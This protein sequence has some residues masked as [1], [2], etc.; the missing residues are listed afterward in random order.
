MKTKLLLSILIFVSSISVYSQALRQTVQNGDWNTNSTWLNGQK[1]QNGD[2]VIIRHNVTNFNGYNIGQ[3]SDA[4][5]TVLPGCSLTGSGTMGIMGNTSSFRNEGYV[6]ISRV[7]P[8]NGAP[9]FI[10]MGICSLSSN[11]TW[12]G[13]TS[14]IYNFGTLHIDGN[15]N[16]QGPSY[17]YNYGTTT[18]TGRQQLL[19][20]SQ[21]H[22]YGTFNVESSL[23]NAEN[24]QQ[25]QIY[26][27]S[28]ANYNVTGGIYLGG[29]S[30]NRIF[31]Y[32]Q[33][34]A[35]YIESHDNSVYENMGTTIVY[36]D[37]NNQGTLNN[38]ESGYIR[39]DR[40]FFNITKGTA[41]VDNEGYI[42]IKEDFTNDR[43]ITGDGNIKYNQNGSNTG[44]ITGT[45][46][47]CDSTPTLNNTV[48][49]NSGSISGSTGNCTSFNPPNPTLVNLSEMSGPINVCTNATGIVFS[50]NNIT[51]P[52]TSYVW[53]V[54][55]GWN[56]VSGQ[57]TNSITVNA[58]NQP[59]A[60]QVIATNTN[61]YAAQSKFVSISGSAPSQPNNINVA[62]T[63]AC[64]G[65]PGLAYSIQPVA[66]ATS[67]TWSVPSGWA[68]VNGQGTTS[69][70]VVPGTTSGTMS[71]TANNG[72]GSSTARTA[73]VSAVGGADAGTDQVVCGTSTNLAANS[74]SGTRF[75]TKISGPASITSS[76]SATTSVTNLGSGLNIFTW[77]VTVSGCTDVDTVIIA[78]N[79][80]A[81]Y[82]RPNVLFDLDS[83]YNIIKNNNHNAN[84]N[85]VLQG[86]VLTTPSDPDGT[87]IS[88]AITN[89]NIPEGVLFNS[90]SGVFSIDDAFSIIPGTYNLTVTT[91]DIFN[92]Q[93]ILSVSLQ[94]TNGQSVNPLPVEFISVEAQVLNNLVNISWSTAWEINNDYFTILKSTDGI[95]FSS[96]GVV[97]GNGTTN[98]I[99]NYN[100]IDYDIQND[101]TFYKIQQTDFDGT[102]DFSP[103]VII[104]N[105][106]QSVSKTNEPKIYPNPV[107]N[108]IVN[109]S[110]E[111]LNVRK[112]YLINSLG[113]S[114]FVSDINSESKIEINT[115]E[116]KSGL[117]YIKLEGDQ[118]TIN[119]LIIIN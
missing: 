101:N 55:S 93:S 85:Q 44:T 108:G 113:Q 102:I 73:T 89:G 35:N 80:S 65:T 6:A 116:Y 77:T 21:V 11:Q 47:I 99:S 24:I 42:D 64:A 78:R 107:N 30:S 62:P 25:G 56:I 53:Q 29:N 90:T 46:A 69:I 26:N 111:N 4:F 82:N 97:L 12:T 13:N 63:S 33:L 48:D 96:I 32:G 76:S 8:V 27:Y 104:R 15:V 1:P 22:N 70:Q 81:S 36:T 106:N 94:F 100:F 20:G 61:G 41:N 50:V 66:N 52:P 9:T 105:N 83:A 5:L 112:I 14:Y 103:V 16:L 72:C 68:I 67:Y 28:G 51:L 74:G 10:N 39:V 118:V 115:K 23:N 43:L 79:C 40:D 91:T 34:T 98:E 71:V 57:G 17:F 37:Y 92:Y 59:G 87:I 18:Q 84:V 75:W 119:P 117:Y 114:I 2:D 31:N 109:I 95:N 86:T 3:N 110:I 54:P 58:N 88:A 38:Y 19:T 7:N 45:N 60:V 49:N